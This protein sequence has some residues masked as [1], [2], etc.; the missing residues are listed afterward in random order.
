MLNDFLNLCG[1]DKNDIEREKENIEK[2]FSLLNITSYDVERSIPFVKRMFDV[3]L[4]GIRK[5]LGVALKELVNMVLARERYKKIIYVTQ[6]IFSPPWEAA[7]EAGGGEVLAVTPEFLL[8]MTMGG[9][10]DKYEFILEAAE[11]K[12][13]RA[14]GAHCGSHQF[15]LGGIAKGIIPIPDLIV[16][17]GSYYC[18]QSGELDNLFNNVYGIPVAYIDGSM[19]TIQD[20]Y[21]A[22]SPRRVQYAA[23]SMRRAEARIE[24][25]IGKKITDEMKRNALIAVGRTWKP[26]QDIVDFLKFDPV[27]ISAADITQLFYLQAIP[28]VYR[29]ELIKAL[30]ILKGELKERVDKGVGI[31][32]KGAPRIYFGMFPLVNQEVAKMVE[33]IGMASVAL[34]IITMCS[35]ERA[36]G[37][38][39]MFEERLIEA[40]H[41][42]GLYHSGLGMARYIK[43]ICAEHKVEGAIIFVPYNC[44]PMSYPA[45]MAKEMVVNELGI[46]A[47][48]LEGDWYDNRDYSAQALRTR[49]ETFAGMLKSRTVKHG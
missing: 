18:D 37:V 9:M 40:M 15:R 13:L 49:V 26:F 45:V 35:D 2:A 1:F 20:D 39:K 38:F 5:C 22:V 17:L 30:D 25:L 23:Q 10:L 19:D 43:D 46:P 8:C 21:P 7:M 3:E 48:L 4:L 11:E 47:M 16:S 32:P 31:L 34:P 29:E 41:K 12:G 44:R 28:L 42:K 24:E 6:P 33:E 36:K 27:P 14:G